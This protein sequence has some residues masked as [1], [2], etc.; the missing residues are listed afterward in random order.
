MHIQPGKKK[1]LV[2]GVHLKTEAYPNTL[3]RLKDLMH[4][5]AFEASEINFPMS[6]ERF[7]TRRHVFQGI[8][9]AIRAA[10]AHAVVIARYLVSSKAD[11]VYVPYPGVFVLFLLSLLPAALRPR[12]LVIDAFISLY[13]TIVTDRRLLKSS[14]LSAHILYWMER[15]AYSISTKVIVDTPQNARFLRALFNLEESKVVAIPLSTDEEHFQVNHY[16][17]KSGICRVLFVGTLVPL[18]GIQTIL[19]AAEILA[20]RKDIVFKLIGDG[21]EA[22]IVEQWQLMHPDTLLWERK[23]QSSAIIANEIEQA[24]I[25]LGIFGAGAKTQRV[26]PFKLYAYACVGRPIITG[27]TEWSS[28]L[29][30]QDGAAYFETVPV[31]DAGKLAAMI[32]QLADD[33]SRRQKLAAGSRLLYE[34]ELSNKIAND[35]LLRCLFSA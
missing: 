11:L 34:R 15:R 13:D 27:H 7:S 23:W 14:G 20:N 35:Q 21:Q 19:D 30:S 18:H 32:A 1:L 26:C 31:G 6:A 22:P 8:W 10:L 12:A 5:D 2:I 17:A 24:D 29:A 28:E 25:C 16:S 9:S 4:S 3:F 33:S